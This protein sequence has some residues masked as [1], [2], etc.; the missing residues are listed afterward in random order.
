MQLR[1]ELLLIRYRSIVGR[2][3]EVGEV[4]LDAIYYDRSSKLIKMIDD[5]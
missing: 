4:R 3:T 2:P 5:L 1:T